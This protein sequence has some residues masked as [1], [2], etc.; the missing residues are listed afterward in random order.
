VASGE[1]GAPQTDP[2]GIDSGM[3]F[4]EGDRPPP[5][6]DLLPGVDVLSGRAVAGP[7]GPVVVEQDHEP[8]VGERSGEPLD[9]VLSGAGVP[10]RHRDGRMQAGPVGL[11]HPCPQRDPTLGAE[12]DIGA[13]HHGHHRLAG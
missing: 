1:A 4:E 7:E 12:L 3:R 11:E 9:A 2:A 13:F 8:G 5:V 10:V 6:R